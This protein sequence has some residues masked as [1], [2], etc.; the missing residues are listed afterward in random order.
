[1]A[2]FAGTDPNRLSGALDEACLRKALE[3]EE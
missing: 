3:P 1:M 2:D